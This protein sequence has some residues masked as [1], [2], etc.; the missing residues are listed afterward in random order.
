MKDSAEELAR[1]CIP[2]VE[3]YYDLLRYESD[4]AGGYK[5][6]PQSLPHITINRDGYRGKPFTGQE[7]VLLLG[8][9]VTFGVGASSDEDRFSR[10][11]ETAAGRPVADASVRAYRVFQHYA[12]LPA[13]LERLPKTR[14]ILLWCGYADL[15]Y[16]VIS[17]GS[18]DGAFGFAQR[19]NGEKPGI[20]AR[21]W[22]RLGRKLRAKPASTAPAVRREPLEALVSQMT[23]HVR[24]IRDLCAAREIELTVL[25]QPFVRARPQRSEVLQ[26]C[27]GYERKTLQKFGKGWYE[28]SQEFVQR[29]GSDLERMFPGNWIDCQALMGEEGYLDQVHL[30]EEAVRR[31]SQTLAERLFVNSG[32]VA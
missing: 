10:Y 15:L 5:L 13:L 7:E 31:L 4:P 22:D 28:L 11:L 23:A 16:W 14:R 25:L 8:D 32:S 30:K 24:A 27:D 12:R 3:E 21:L 6:A 20:A 18:V 26:I 17:G 1:N 9:S 29:F 19:Y 2:H